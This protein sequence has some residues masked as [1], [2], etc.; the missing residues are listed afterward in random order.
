ME[1]QRGPSRQSASSDVLEQISP[2]RSNLSQ[3]ALRISLGIRTRPA[4]QLGD[5]LI[6]KIEPV[7]DACAQRVEFPSTPFDDGKVLTVRYEEIMAPAR[8]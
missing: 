5:G 3:T 7:S 6:A 2:L 8:R 1:N 4:Y